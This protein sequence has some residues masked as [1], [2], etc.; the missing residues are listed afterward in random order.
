M[1]SISGRA[2][3]SS[4]QYAVGGRQGK[5]KKDFFGS[6]KKSWMEKAGLCPHL[7]R[8]HP[9]PCLFGDKGQKII[10]NP[11][12]YQLDHSLPHEPR[13]GTKLPSLLC[14]N[15]AVLKPVDS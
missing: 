8:S 7:A 1:R 12:S 10:C 13:T 4:R 15:V 3:R 14:R 2:G 9:A 11:V 5:K 6:W